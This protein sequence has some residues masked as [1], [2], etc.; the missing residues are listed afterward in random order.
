MTRKRL[1]LEQ[2]FGGFDFRVPW[3]RLKGKC[4]KCPQR[5]K[6]DYS[7]SVSRG[8]LFS[9]SPNNRFQLSATKRTSDQ[10]W[11]LKELNWQFCCN[12]YPYLPFKSWVNKDKLM[13][14]KK[15]K[16]LMINE[17]KLI[18]LYLV[19]RRVEVGSFAI[20]ISF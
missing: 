19:L 20:C 16:F 15:K 8:F 12:I 11:L 4:C 18:F 10:M 3:G 14:K 7:V 1:S 9:V 13:K 5:R 17:D 2:F 6:K